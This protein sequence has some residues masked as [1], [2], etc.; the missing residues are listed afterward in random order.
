MFETIGFGSVWAF[1]LS[2]VLWLGNVLQRKTIILQTNLAIETFV[3]QSVV[4][5]CVFN[6]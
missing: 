5:K 4:R 6:K 1:V 2:S 3:K